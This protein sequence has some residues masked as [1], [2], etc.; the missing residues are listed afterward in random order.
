MSICVGRHF[1]VN[2][3]ATKKD[4]NSITQLIKVNGKVESD[5]EK[6]KNC[7]AENEIISTELEISHKRR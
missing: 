2:P 1:L 4:V 6:D 5:K 3:I 7:C